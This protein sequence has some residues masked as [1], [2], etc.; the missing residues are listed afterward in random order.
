MAKKIFITGATGFI[1]GRLAELL[2]ERGEEVKTLVRPTSNFQRLSKL[3]LQIVLGDILEPDSFRKVLSSCEVLYHCAGLVAPWLPDKR[4]FYKVNADGTRNV[5]KLALDLNISKVVHTSSVAAIGQRVGEIGTEET[6]HRGYFFTTYEHSKYMGE[7]V[8]W[9]FYKNGLP[10]VVVNPS[11]V[12]GPADRNFGRLIDAFL[13]RR[14]PALLSPQGY[15][16]LVFVDDVATGHILAMEKGEVGQRY[17]LSSA[18]V[19]TRDF[20]SLLSRASGIATPKLV[21]P[22]WLAY[23]GLRSAEL[24]LPVLGIRPPLSSEWVRGGGRGA[25]FDGTRASRELGLVYTPLEEA[26]SRTVSWYKARLREK[27][28]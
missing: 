12:F 13:K 18:N 9:E 23:T 20:F 22:Q 16:A 6:Q 17:I 19:T 26:L 15:R 7:Q 8:A 14:I 21:I 11:T 10:V 5:L 2:V 25:R 28:L 1:G 24:L 4:L 3:G 27:E